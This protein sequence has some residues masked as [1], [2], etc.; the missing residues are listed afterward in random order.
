MLEEYFFKHDVQ[1]DK[2]SDEVGPGKRS[3]NSDSEASDDEGG[4]GY[5]V[6]DS[7]AD[8][9]SAWM[10]RRMPTRIQN[11]TQAQYQRSKNAGPK[12]VLNDYKAYKQQEKLQLERDALIRQATLLRIANGCVESAPREE[13]PSNNVPEDS[14]DEFM[15]EFRAKR[16]QEMLK[17]DTRPQFGR[18]EYVEPTEF[19]DIVDQIDARSTVVIHLYEPFVNTC[20]TLNKAMENL[21][22][23]H[24]RVRFLCLEASKA[25]YTIDHK[26]LPVFMVYQGGELIHTILNVAQ[27]VEGVVNVET[28]EWL[29]T[30]YNT[31]S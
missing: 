16:L 23:K 20:Q 21:A 24:R 29:L 22:I 8:P 28:I 17:T 27:L 18:L 9:A 30:E 1:K 31:L 19:V 5:G 10:E 15:K 26:G 11:A 14:D 7:A 2:D 6:A 4:G 12:G 13:I 3:T 25:D